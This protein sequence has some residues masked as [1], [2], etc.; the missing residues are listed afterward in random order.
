MITK[1]LSWYTMRWL[2][3]IMTVIRRNI[4]CV[5]HDCDNPE[6]DEH[7]FSKFQTFIEDNMSLVIAVTQFRSLQDISY[8]TDIV[9]KRRT[10]THQSPMRPYISHSP[11]NS[12][13]SITTVPENIRPTLTL[14]SS[15]LRRYVLSENATY[16]RWQFYM[17]P[18]FLYLTIGQEFHL[19][20]ISVMPISGRWLRNHWPG[21]THLLSNLYI[22]Y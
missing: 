21:S 6:V 4:L 8:H 14:Y 16:L 5:L 2:P 18:Y 20:S 22:I 10:E 13:M 17:D 15:S 9:R 19:L 12:K 1:T 11:S 7:M 3:E